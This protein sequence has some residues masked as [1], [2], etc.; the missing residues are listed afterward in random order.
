MSIPSQIKQTSLTTNREFND[1]KE[2]KTYPTIK[3][4]KE[5]RNTIKRLKKEFEKIET[6]TLIKC[7]VSTVPDN[8]FMWKITI[9]MPTCDVYLDITFPHNYPLK[10]PTITFSEENIEAMIYNK[11]QRICLH[12]LHEWSPL[13]TMTNV[14]LPLYCKIYD[15]YKLAQMM[16]A[17][18]PDPRMTCIYS[19]NKCIYFNRLK[20]IL[21]KY[22]EMD[23]INA[24]AVDLVDDFA[25]LLRCHN[26]DNE[27]EYIYHQLGGY[28]DLE[29]CN[30]FGRHRNNMVTNDTKIINT[31]LDAVTQIIDKIHCCYS[32][33]YDIGNRFTTKEQQII[34]M[35]G[36]RNNNQL[37]DEKIAT[38]TQILS[39]K[40]KNTHIYKRLNRFSLLND[41]SN[42]DHKTINDKLYHLGVCFSYKESTTKKYSI[43][44]KKD[45]DSSLIEQLITK[46]IMVSTIVTPKYSSLKDEMINNGITSIT[47]EKFD[48]EYTKAKIHFNS[49]YCK[50]RYIKY[51]HG[52]TLHH[53]L[54]LIIYCNCDNL[55]HQFSKTYRENWHQ[56]NEFYHLG[57]FLQSSVQS[58]GDETTLYN[59]APGAPVYD[60]YHGAQ[61][62]LLFPYWTIVSRGA[63]LNC[64]VSTSSVFAVAANFA[65]NGLIFKF[66]DAKSGC[67]TRYFPVSWLSDYPNESEYL[68]LQSNIHGH[69]YNYQTIKICNIFDLKTGC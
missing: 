33:C 32:H 47:V 64:P 67:S 59:Y 45:Q 48:N 35:N 42:S 26:N 25:H 12:I 20:T 43:K 22:D 46:G 21:I 54:S 2:Q 13:L 15:Q 5:E 23:E 27:F 58:F 11:N 14:L 30:R 41:V 56:H 51:R 52:F 24:N 50:T 61:G 49:N 44:P 10:P 3:Q 40:R 53:I 7:R 6:S 4:T 18:A 39:S 62:S 38:A 19:A 8:I 68:F 65:N 28:C 63:V 17:E 34:E 66:S 9:T 60:F 37:Y 29:N 1:F 55:Q 57:K 16:N 69:G 36:T 31:D